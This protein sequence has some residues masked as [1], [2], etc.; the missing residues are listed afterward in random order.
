MHVTT[1]ALDRAEQDQFFSWMLEQIRE[2]D[3]PSPVLFAHSEMV[4]AAF[5]A[6]IAADF[7]PVPGRDLVEQ[8]RTSLWFARTLAV[9]HYADRPGFQDK[10]RPVRF[11]RPDRPGSPQ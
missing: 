10:W 1:P 11:Q 3:H 8:H 2:S 9:G 4:M 5:G 6:A 7:D